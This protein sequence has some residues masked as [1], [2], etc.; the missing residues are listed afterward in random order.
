VKPVAPVCPFAGL[1]F[2]SIQLK[3]VLVSSV[4]ICF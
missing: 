3:W 1:T 4:V 2:H